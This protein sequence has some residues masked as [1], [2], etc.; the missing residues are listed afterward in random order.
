MGW[1][2]R[3]FKSFEDFKSRL[4]GLGAKVSDLTI[5]VGED[6]RLS[7]GELGPVCLFASTVAVYEARDVR[8]KTLATFSQNYGLSTLAG[9]GL[10]VRHH[11]VVDLARREATD[12]A[13]ELYAYNPRVI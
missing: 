12:R 2:Q 4:E 10:Y 13:R 3:R 8:G 6:G 5:L 7:G 11:D 1:L 9:G